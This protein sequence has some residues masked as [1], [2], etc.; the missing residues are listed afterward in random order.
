MDTLTLGMA[1]DK[2][3][4]SIVRLESLV[5]GLDSSPQNVTFAFASHQ[6]LAVTGSAENENSDH[7]PILG[8]SSSA[9]KVEVEEGQYLTTLILGEKHYLEGAN[10][11]VV[12][13]K[14]KDFSKIKWKI[15]QDG[16]LKSEN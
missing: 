16:S 12:F 5:G 8:S 4:S 10:S 3:D 2:S 14:I 11:G 9:I 15:E 7:V 13:T 6:G 1:S